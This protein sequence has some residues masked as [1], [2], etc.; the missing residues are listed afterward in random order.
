LLPRF[1]ADFEA[2][3]HARTLRSEF[4]RLKPTFL[5]S[6]VES[7]W[8]SKLAAQKAILGWRFCSSG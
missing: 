5:L 6:K 7:I 2:V 8:V 1:L 4:F 3:L